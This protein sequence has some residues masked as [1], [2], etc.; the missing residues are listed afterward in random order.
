MGEQ[1]FRPDRSDALGKAWRGLS[2]PRRGKPRDLPTLP[3]WP[4]L[5]D[6]PSQAAW[7][8]LDPMVPDESHPADE[9]QPTE[10][11]GTL[12]PAPPVAPLPPVP[13]ARRGG[14]SGIARRF[15][16]ASKRARLG[17]TAAVAVVLVVLIVVCSSFALRTAG[18][19]VPG[20]AAPGAAGQGGSATSLATVTPSPTRQPTPTRA[21]TST[22]TPLPPLTLA[23]ICASG[24]IRGTGQVCVH[25]LPQAGLSLTV[26]YCDGSSAK[27]LHGGVTADGSGNYTWTWYV[28]TTC[29]GPA[30]ATV[31][32]TANGQ[33]LTESDTFTI[34]R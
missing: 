5:P 25:T 21:P 19:I 28:R 1:Q 30:T 27:G 7:P 2:E 24:Q 29:L 23:F 8:S 12:W 31:T 13:P 6:E 9:L 3:D 10:T 26:R 14:G 34:T 11:D 18:G 17:I 33:S 22:A 32:A 20:E 16:G 4:P 15:R